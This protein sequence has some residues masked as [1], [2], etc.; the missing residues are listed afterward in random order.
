MRDSTQAHQGFY[1][2][3]DGSNPAMQAGFAS[4]QGGQYTKDLKVKALTIYQGRIETIDRSSEERQ[5]QVD[6]EES[7]ACEH[8]EEGEKLEV[9]C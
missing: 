7:N 8:G 2:E 1:Y 9:A 4:L 3:G 6:I 5:A